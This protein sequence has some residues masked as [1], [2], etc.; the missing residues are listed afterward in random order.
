[1]SSRIESPT[2]GRNITA[3]LALVLLACSADTSIDGTGGLTPT[4]VTAGTGTQS[5][6]QAQFMANGT[7]SGGGGPCQNLECRRVQ[8]SGGVTTTISGTVYEPAG[9]VP[10]YNVV[11]YV[12]N[13]PVEPFVDGARCDKCDATLADPVSSAITDTKGEFTL[14]NVP[15]GADIPLV[16][17]VGKFRRQLVIP[18]VNE[19]V[20]NPLADKE[21]TRLPRNKSE[22]DIPKIALAT[23]GADPLECLLRK[24]GIDDA[25]FTTEAGDGRVNLFAGDGGGNRYTTNLNGGAA[26]SEASA[27]LWDQTASLMKY[28]LVLMACEGGQN[29][30]DKPMTSRQAL[31]DYTAAGGRVFLSHWHNVWLELGPSPW[32]DTA[33]FNHQADLDNPFTAKINQGFPKGAAL[34]EWLVNVDGST[35]LGEIE[36][37]EGQHTVDDVNPMYSTEWIYGDNPMSTQYLTFNTPVDLP[38]EQQCGRVVLSDIHVSSGDS[39]GDPFPEGCTTMDLSPQEKALMFMLFDLSACI[40]PDDEPPTPPS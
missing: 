27:S 4:A 36:I 30:G 3:G 37:R 2:P 19:C 22:G 8:C 26:F 15:V 33:V 21:Q 24:I 11:V 9:K 34:A 39:I 40:I 6:S 14:E 32:P 38:E 17:Q 5:G 31:V 16:I 1:M 28:D 18:M 23:G 35:T 29:E 25:E 12:P 13:K 7:G 20:D 10:L